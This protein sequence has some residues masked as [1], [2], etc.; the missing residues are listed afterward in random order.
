[1]SYLIQW[2]TNII[3]FIL[4]ATVIDMLLPNS[5]MQKYTKLVTGLLLI[6]IILTP[7]LKLTSSNFDS[8]LAS[9]PNFSSVNENNMKNSIEMKKNEIQATD[10]A[11]ILEQMAVQLKKGVAE[12][13]MKKYSL[14][15]DKVEISTNDKSNQTFPNN[16]QKLTVHLKQPADN[17][18]AVE[19]VKPIEINTKK[20]FSSKKMADKSAEISA[21]LSKKWNVDEKTIEVSIEGGDG[22]KNG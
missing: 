4:L 19:V 15:I 2:V 16:L 10:H 5:S 12:E 22:N 1:M 14:E 8:M 13:L 3:L 11:Y 6:A 17:A 18:L 21:F 7:I 9:L 20:P